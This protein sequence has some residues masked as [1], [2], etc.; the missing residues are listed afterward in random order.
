MTRDEAVALVLQRLGNRSGTA[1]EN[2]VIADMQLAQIELEQAVEKPWFLLS[3]R[4][5]LNNEASPTDEL[6]LPDDFLAEYKDGL[7]QVDIDGTWKKVEKLDGKRFEA[8]DDNVYS[9]YAPMFYTLAKDKIFLRAD[10][11]EVLDFRWDYFAK[12]D[13]LSTDVTNLW[14][15]NVPEVLICAAGVKSATFLEAEKKI[16]SFQNG[17]TSALQAMHLYSRRF[18]ESNE[19]MSMEYG[20]D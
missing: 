9:D 10:P 17:L 7:L 3:S 18:F 2:R 13:V 16:Q 11:E 4:V 6:L 20:H 15:T 1:V 8:V 12:D 14:L 19:S 5:A